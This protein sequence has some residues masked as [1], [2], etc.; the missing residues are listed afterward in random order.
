M[1]HRESSKMVSRSWWNYLVIGFAFYYAL[2]FIGLFFMTAPIMHLL[3]EYEP[4]M[5]TLS[6]F[7][8]I[9][10]S[11]LLGSCIGILLR[12][13]IA[14]YVAFIALFVIGFSGIIKNIAIEVM[15]PVIP[16]GP[17]GL[18]PDIFWYVVV[19]S[20]I[21]AYFFYNLK[22]IEIQ[23]SSQKSRRRIKHLPLTK[24]IGKFL[25]YLFAITSIIFVILVAYFSIFPG[26]IVPQE[27]NKTVTAKNETYRIYEEIPITE[28]AIMKIRGITLEDKF[29]REGLHFNWTCSPKPDHKFIKVEF[30]R[31]GKPYPQRNVDLPQLYPFLLVTKKGYVY[32]DVLEIISKPWERCEITENWEIEKYWCDYFKWTETT[33]HYPAITLECAFFEIPKDEEIAKFILGIGSEPRRWINI[34][35]E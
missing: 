24:R 2:G 22:K 26:G 6:Y 5:Y 32:R 14:Y 21:G 16:A 4:T 31:E 23:Q 17:G 20:G 10:A 11:I 25:L 33:L 35:L 27:E 13:K 34:L 9:G 15:T 8:V 19:P 1:I 29:I 7:Q 3:A 18:I 12:K 28:R 30:W